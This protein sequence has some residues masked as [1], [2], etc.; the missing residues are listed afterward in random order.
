MYEEH[1]IL[2]YGEEVREKEKKERHQQM[3]SIQLVNPSWEKIFLLHT[4]IESVSVIK[5]NVQN[6]HGPL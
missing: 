4:H 6:K 3:M 5:L 1:S 2:D